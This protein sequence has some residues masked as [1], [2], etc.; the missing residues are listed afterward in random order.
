MDFD[1]PSLMFRPSFYISVC[2][3][4]SLLNIVT[5]IEFQDEAAYNFIY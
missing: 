5:H 4:A 1:A 2:V 3:M